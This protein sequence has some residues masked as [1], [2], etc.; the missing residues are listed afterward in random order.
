MVPFLP[1]LNNG[2]RV[3]IALACL[4]HIAISSPLAAAG[5]PS[6]SLSQP[7]T[8]LNASEDHVHQ[9][10]LHCN[11]LPAWIGAD[12]APYAYRPEDCLRAVNLFRGDMGKAHNVAYQ[13]LALGAVALPELGQPVYLPRRYTWGSCTLTL[14]SLLD[15]GPIPDKPPTTRTKGSERVVA[16]WTEIG[17]SVATLGST[18]VLE[19]GAVGWAPYDVFARQSTIRSTPLGIFFWAT[20]SEID[21]SV[22]D[23]SKVGLKGDDVD[24]L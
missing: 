18:C 24:F 22:P 21:K 11:R 3:L 4:T 9:N 6:L 16:K 10:S 23:P 12:S 17:R 2:V 5:S 1:L 19:A 7:S 20:G 13:W 14:A 8:A 15:V